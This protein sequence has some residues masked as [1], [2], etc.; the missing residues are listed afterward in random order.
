MILEVLWFILPAYSANCMPVLVK[1]KRPLDKGKMF[2]GNRILGDGKTIEGTVAGILFG[3]LIGLIQIAS[4]GYIFEYISEFGLNLFPMTYE[5]VIL[6]SIGAIVG[7]ICGSFIK[8]RFSVPRGNL[9]IFLDQLDFVFG[10]LLFV[11]PFYLPSFY[12]FLVLVAI[13]LVFHIFSNFIAYLVKLKS[14]PY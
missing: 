6:L 2:H 1:G 4:Q 8:R 11:S 5:I 10:A 9:V 13:T 3:I 14:R 12:F 7:D